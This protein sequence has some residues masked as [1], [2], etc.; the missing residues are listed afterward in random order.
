MFAYVK[1]ANTFGNIYF[2][3]NVSNFY[4]K[5]TIQFVL[6]IEKKKNSNSNS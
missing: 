3:K 6:Q 4:K 1:I 2:Y 5:I